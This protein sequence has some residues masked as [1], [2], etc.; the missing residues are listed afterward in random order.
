MGGLGSW[1]LGEVSRTECY[2]AVYRDSH[3]LSVVVL[4]SLCLI[5]AVDLVIVCIFLYFCSDLAFA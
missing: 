5:E 3:R 4:F 1:L 2:M